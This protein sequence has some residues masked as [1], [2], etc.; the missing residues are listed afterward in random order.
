MAIEKI[1]R[2]VKGNKIFYDPK[3]RKQGTLLPETKEMEYYI[4]RN[5]LVCMENPYKGKDSYNE[6]QERKYEINEEA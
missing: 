4:D 2:C 6:I 5:G 3:T 1:V